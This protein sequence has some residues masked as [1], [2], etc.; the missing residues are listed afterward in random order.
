MGGAHRPGRGQRHSEACQ[1]HVLHGL[2]HVPVHPWGGGP[3]D[4]PGPLH[5]G[6]V[7]C[8]GGQ[9][10]I[11]GGQAVLLSGEP[12]QRSKVDIWRVLKKKKVIYLR[13]AFQI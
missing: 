7:L 11:Q 10:V 9:Q 3:Q 8:R 5:A 1:K 13:L 4:H 2:L 6:R 12:W